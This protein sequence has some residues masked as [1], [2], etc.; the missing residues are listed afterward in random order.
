MLPVIQQSEFLIDGIALFHTNW[1]FFT[2]LANVYIPLPFVLQSSEINKS[3]KGT[4]VLR[5][6]RYM[7]TL[8]LFHI[9]SFEM[10]LIVC[11]NLKTIPYV[12]IIAKLR[13][14]IEN[15]ISRLKSTTHTKRFHD[16]TLP[17]NIRYLCVMQC[18]YKEF[19]YLLEQEIS[20]ITQQTF[21]SPFTTTDEGRLEMY[22]FAS[23]FGQN[24]VVHDILPNINVDWVNL[25]EIIV[26]VATDYV[27]KDHVL[28][29][30]RQ[31]IQDLFMC[32]PN[33]EYCNAG[34]IGC[35]NFYFIPKV[36]NNDVCFT[37]VKLYSELT[38]YVKTTKAFKT[39]EIASFLCES[40]GSDSTM[41][42]LKQRRMLQTIKKYIDQCNGVMRCVKSLKTYTFVSARLECLVSVLGGTNH[43]E[44]VLDYCKR[45]RDLNNF[46]NVKL[47][48]SLPVLC[49]QKRIESYVGCS[50]STI[51][52]QLN[53]LRYCL[54]EGDKI[55]GF[56]IG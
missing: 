4:R 19:G 32:E 39:S 50:I 33:Y 11:S 36:M 22:F 7:W 17:D 29:W 15:C 1:N 53:Q 5:N 37:L 26:H 27:L 52:S 12:E 16:Q 48:K 24:A 51:L 35:G 3:I 34:V 46:N 8:K 13:V 44:Q 45:F 25:S 43:W 6:L 54:T 42:K 2:P 47:F 56:S 41:S 40:E 9:N 14:A 31:K 28:L 20:G 30:D 21:Y 23:A 38:K 49:L 10:K 18:D 55:F